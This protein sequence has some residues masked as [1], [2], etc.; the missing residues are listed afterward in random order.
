MWPQKLMHTS[1]SLIIFHKNLGKINLFALTYCGRQ[2]TWINQ[3]NPETNGFNLSALFC[4][5]L[6][7]QRII[8]VESGQNITL[9]C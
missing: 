9:T 4:F 7:D 5:S 1:L 3:Q 6:S 8:P 2:Q